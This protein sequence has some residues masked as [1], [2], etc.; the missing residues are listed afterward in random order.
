MAAAHRPRKQPG[1]TTMSFI[2]RPRAE[3]GEALRPGTSSTFAL[4]PRIRR[5][6]PRRQGQAAPLTPPPAPG[7]ARTE[8]FKETPGYRAGWR[9]DEGLIGGSA[10]EDRDDEGGRPPGRSRGLH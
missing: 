4:V 7:E 3:A 2:G 9:G 6:G 5:P 8:P 1:S 10:G